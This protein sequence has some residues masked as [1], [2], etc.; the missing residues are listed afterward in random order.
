MAVFIG[1]TGPAGAGKGTIADT[2]SNVAKDRGIKVEKFSLSDE[3]RKESKREDK[4]ME[5]EIFKQTANKFRSNFGN[6]VWARLVI[7]RIEDQMLKSDDDRILFIIDSIRNPGEV[8]ELRSRFGDRFKL[9][10][11]SAPPKVVSGNL[12]RR[13]RSDESEKVLDDEQKL[14]D[15]HRTEMG[16]GEPEYG[17]NVS[18]CIEMADLPVIY[19]DG[20]LADL[21][22]KTIELANEFI[23]QSI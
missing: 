4:P 5:R 16:A 3:V 20:S 13:K 7:S 11:V 15:L 9:I 12:K 17:L 19:N 18:A 21:E 6:G 2:L 23:L 22:R 8:R 1:L 10:G 14:H